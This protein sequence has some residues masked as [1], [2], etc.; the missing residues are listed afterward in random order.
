M[1]F[2]G[3]GIWLS[4]PRGVARSFPRGKSRA[5]V[6]AGAGCFVP[7]SGAGYGVSWLALNRSGSCHGQLGGTRGSWF[8]RGGLEAIGVAAAAQLGRLGPGPLWSFVAGVS[9]AR[10]VRDLLAASRFT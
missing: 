3:G 5:E 8:P 4:D 2:F 7:L 10:P 9:G 6:T 1:A